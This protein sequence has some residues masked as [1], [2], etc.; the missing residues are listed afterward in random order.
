MRHIKRE[1]YLLALEKL[2]DPNII[3]NRETVVN[4]AIL[5][6]GV[7]QTQPVYFVKEHYCLNPHYKEDY[8][9]FLDTRYNSI[10]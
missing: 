10:E 8:K 3:S 7:Y 4:V 9:W 2:L 6:D 1:E 5:K